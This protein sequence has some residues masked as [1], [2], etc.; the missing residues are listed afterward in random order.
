MLHKPAR[1]PL[2][3]S[4]WVQ[5]IL[6]CSL[7]IAPIF[8]HPI[9]AGERFYFWQSLVIGMFLVALNLWEALR[10]HKASPKK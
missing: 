2:S 3:Y 10:D 4:R 7:I 8:Q 1:Q 6:G 5:V 9:T